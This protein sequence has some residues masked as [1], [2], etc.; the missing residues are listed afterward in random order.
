[1]TLR[2]AQHL[3][4]KNF[5][6]INDK[7]DPEKGKHWTPFATA[8]DL[9]EK[10]GDIARAIN[11]LEDSQSDGKAETKVVLA[12]QLSEL[13]YT[14]LVLEEHYGINLEESF[15]QSMDDYILKFIK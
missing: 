14:I 8:T 2:D 11:A 5:R 15:L 4:W 6:K 12:T 9:L 3:C 13:L 10:S 7:L 1:L